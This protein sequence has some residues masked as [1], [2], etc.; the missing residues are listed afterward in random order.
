M[1]L[2]P[3]PEPVPFEPKELATGSGTFL[4]AG[5]RDR[6]IGVHYYK[7]RA[8]G[9]RSRILLV[10]PGAGR[11]GDSYRDAWIE[12]AEAAN[13]LVAAL[14]YPE[15]DYD[16]AAYHMGGVVKDLEIRNLPP[17]GAA[18]AVIRVRDE[19][20]SFSL[21]PRRDEW[22]FPDFDRIFGL[23][24]AATG[25]TQTAYDMF[26]HSAGAQILHRMVL[27]APGS[28]ADRIVAA[29]SGF[30]TLADAD[31]PLPVGLKGT[32][33]TQASLARSFAS[34]LMLLV[35]EKDDGDEAGGI[36]IHTPLIDNQGIG[37]LARG[38]YFFR[39]A[40]ERARKLRLPFRWSLE[41]V[42]DVGHDFRAMSRAAAR[43]LFS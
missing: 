14:S 2:I 32:D 39:D 40:E 33:V 30:Y 26:G 35:G 17:G 19:D 34:K 20:I 1:T 43:A 21:N 12:A 10:I 6:R 29:N 27:F 7:P 5:S 3:K 18:A 9:A 11:N 4:A 22:I 41:V 15:A 36:Q 16:F 31:Q 8:F 37:R 25:S 28:R 23:I 24:T 38:K 13:V 42:P